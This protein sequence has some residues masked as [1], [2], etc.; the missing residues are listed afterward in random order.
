TSNNSYTSMSVV[1]WNNHIDELSVTKSVSPEEPYIGEEVEFTIVVEKPNNQD[2]AS[3]SLELIDKLPPG[4]TY[5]SHTVSQGTYTPSTGVWV[6]QDTWRWTGTETLTITARVNAPTGVPDEY[7]SIATIFSQG[8]FPDTEISNNMAS[9]TIPTPVA[10]PASTDLSITKTV[11]NA[12]PTVLSNVVF[13]L[14]AK[15]DG[16]NDTTGVMVDDLLPAGFAHVSDNGAGAY[17]PNTGEWN[18]GALANGAS[19]TLI[20][21]AKVIDTE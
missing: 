11:N 15:N 5:I 20:I 9:A 12:S 17:N 16:P 1:Y 6:V 8:A 14:T 10:D 13:T 18:V 4:Y 19:K 7:K 3:G 2:G 21:T